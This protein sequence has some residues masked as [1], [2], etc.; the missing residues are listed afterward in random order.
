MENEPLEQLAREIVNNENKYEIIKE[1]E[2][3]LEGNYT[4]CRFLALLMANGLFKK[5]YYKLSDE[6]SNKNM[7]SKLY[8]LI[9]KNMN[10]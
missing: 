9:L 2:W 3:Y 4:K 10:E 7:L 8:N 5:E 6:L 1:I